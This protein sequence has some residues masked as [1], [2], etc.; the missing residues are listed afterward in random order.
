MVVKYANLL[1]KQLLIMQVIPIHRLNLI[2]EP[3]WSTSELIGV[4]FKN[5]DPRNPEA[6]KLVAWW[7]LHRISAAAKDYY[8][9]PHVP[10]FVHVF[11]SFIPNVKNNSLWTCYIDYY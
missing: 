11:F 5:Q 7:H 1:H 3:I 10:I 6:Q 9:I 2:L 4:A 8:V